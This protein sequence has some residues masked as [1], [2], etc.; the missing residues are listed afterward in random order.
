MVFLCPW[1]HLFLS[2]WICLSI[3]YSFPHVYTISDSFDSKASRFNHPY[4]FDKLTLSAAFIISI[5]RNIALSLH[6]KRH[7][8]SLCKGQ[9]FLAWSKVPL[10]Q[11]LF[12]FP[13]FAKEIVVNVRKGSSSRNFPMLLWF[14]QLWLAH[15]YLQDRFCL[16]D[17]ETTPQLYS[18]QNNMFF[19]STLHRS[20]Q[21]HASF[22]S[23]F[24]IRF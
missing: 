11:L 23:T 15:K 14:E 13:R 2:D 1:N 7:T 22:K 8:S 21:P 24:G 4:I 10:S 20:A 3:C 18:L 5:Q 12:N 16:L 9:H 19:R 17:N 6:K